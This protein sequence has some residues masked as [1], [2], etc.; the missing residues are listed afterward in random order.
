MAHAGVQSSSTLV[1]LR[2]LLGAAESGFTQTAMYYMSTMYPKY[3]LG[4]RLG[5]FSGM[6]S[7]AGAFTGLIAYGLLSIESTSLKG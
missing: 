3:T 2:L 1:A 6:Y 5:L 4:S 7:V